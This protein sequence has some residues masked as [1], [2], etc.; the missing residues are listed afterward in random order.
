[1]SELFFLD[2]IIKYINNIEKNK[3]YI[4]EKLESILESKYMAF[5]NNE[6]LNYLKLIFDKIHEIKSLTEN[7][8]QILN[9]YRNK[10]NIK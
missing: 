7:E 2:I 9:K 3:I 4:L 10:F 8:H 5:L 6:H 1:M